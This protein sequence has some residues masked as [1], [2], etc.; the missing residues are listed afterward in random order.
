[1][2]SE[3]VKFSIDQETGMLR[4]DD[5]KKYFS[6]FGWFCFAFFGISFVFSLLVSALVAEVAPALFG[7][8][9]FSHAVS[10]IGLYAVALPIALPILKKLPK[11]D[12]L[13]DKLGFAKLLGAICVS[14]ALML[15]GNMIT[16]NLILIFEAAKG[17]GLENP[18]AVATDG[19]PWW[20]TLIFMVILAPILEEVFFRKIV[21]QRLLPLGEG[22]AIVLSSI[23]FALC[24]GNFFQIFYAFALGCL[25]SLI[26]VK[27]GKLRYTVILHMAVNFMGS[28]VSS[29]I[30][31]F[32]KLEDIL[33][34]YESL[35]KL[36]EG[37]NTEEAQGAVVDALMQFATSFG[38]QLIVLL[39]Y[40][41]VLYGLAITGTVLL[42]TK[43]KKIRLTKGLLTPPSKSRAGVILL[44]SG[45]AASIALFTIV[46]ILSLI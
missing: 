11:V 44:N 34:E 23:F 32:V 30:L 45:I 9:W 7:H 33:K 38:P 12:P 10:F 26:Y 40:E 28:L 5:A 3:S 19:A 8:S 13:E 4:E 2:N 1:M 24:H 16:Q 18:V 17:T 37:A 15:I 46:L 6:I 31:K 22:F 39:V 14:F 43:F 36:V 35:M 41:V 42:L 29:L 27:T 25:F 20:S 21:C